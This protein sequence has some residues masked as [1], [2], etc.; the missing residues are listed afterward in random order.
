M[1][2]WNAQG[3]NTKPFALATENI[4]L[5]EARFPEAVPD[6]KAAFVVLKQHHSDA[7]DYR[8]G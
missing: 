7:T 6:C 2:K 1:R 4:E 3:A 5:L 8:E